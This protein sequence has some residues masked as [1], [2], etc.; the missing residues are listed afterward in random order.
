MVSLSDPLGY[1]EAGR[2]KR[3]SATTATEAAKAPCFPMAYG[4][5]ETSPELLFRET[6][7]IPD[8]DAQ[9][10]KQRVSRR[11]VTILDADGTALLFFFRLRGDH[12]EKAG[13]SRPLI[14]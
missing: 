11:D 10:W 12:L 14:R 13:L 7:Q 9:E 8:S 2:E 6:T 3:L 4:Y 5:T 1:A